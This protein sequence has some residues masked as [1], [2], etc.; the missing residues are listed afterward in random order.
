MSVVI[1]IMVAESESGPDAMKDA[2]V[3]IALCAV[4]VGMWPPIAQFGSRDPAV[5]TQEVTKKIVAAA[6]TEPA[7]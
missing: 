7:K 4:L 5:L 1:G 2:F 3:A 6:A